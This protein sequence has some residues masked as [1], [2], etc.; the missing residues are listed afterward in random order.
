[1]LTPEEWAVLALSLQVGVCCVLLSLPPAV[2]L[3]W[4]LAR[5]A[6]RG[7]MILDGVCHLP[8]VLPPT[9][10]GY[11]VLVGLGGGSP[12]GQSVPVT[13]RRYNRC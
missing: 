6:F 7:K 10:L 8:L 11:Y 2:L 9:V 12:I 5:T 1:M 4:V 13:A 3:G